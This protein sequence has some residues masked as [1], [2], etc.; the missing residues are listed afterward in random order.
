MDKHIR[1]AALQCNFQTE[2]ETLNMPA[3]WNEI[4]FN[5]EQLLQTHADLYSAVYDPKRHHDLLAKYA[6]NARKNNIRLIIYMNVHILGPS[7]KEHYDE[8]CT[9]DENG[10]PYK[11]YRTYPG[12]CLNSG[13]REYFYSCL[14]FLK[15]F[16]IEGIFFDGPTM[17]NCHCPHCQALFKKQTGKE[18]SEAT[19][20]EIT[21]FTT[22]N[23]MEFK[24]ELYRKV[25]EINPAWSSYYNEGL[26]SGRLDAEQMAYSL[27]SDDIIGTE[28]GFFFYDEP[29]KIPYWKCSSA[30]KLAEAVAGNKQTVVFFAG[31]HKAWGWFMHTDSE[32]KLCYTSAIANGASVW[33]GVH[34]RPDSLNRD[35]GK[36]IREM[37]QFDKKHD[38]LY[39]N[40][41]SAA[42]T[43]VFYSFNTAAYYAKSAES[44][45]L[46]NADARHN[47]KTPGN[48]TEAFQGALAALEHL[49]VPFDIVTELA[50][51]ALMKYKT[52]LVPGMA[53]LDDTS[54]AAMKQFVANG[55]LLIADGE[56]GFFDG[57]GKPRADLADVAELTGARPS[58]E[59]M[60]MQNFNYISVTDKTFYNDNAFGYI[61]APRWCYPLT[62]EAGAESAVLAPEPMAGCYASR[63][64]V[65]SIPVAASHKFGK[66]E[67]LYFAGGLFE[68]YG[69]YQIHVLR[70]W[71]AHLLA[72][73]PATYRLLGAKPGISITVR[74]C[75]E[76][77]LVHLTNFLGITRPLDGVIPLAGMKLTA[78]EAT[79]TDLRTG[80]SLSK[81][82]DGNFILPVQTEYAVFLLS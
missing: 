47:A 49:S 67:C 79:A 69:K 17:T 11:L 75:S 68:F 62:L 53:M 26:F 57:K 21:A 52:I 29:R 28:G 32:L 61:P 64:G 39:Q 82:A 6:E 72:K 22:R 71:F 16:D 59:W 77:T 13:W 37:V 38:A 18:M 55:G 76:G 30:A 3:R 25:K 56:F 66:G 31:D 65:P 12:S 44:S 7:L 74:K 41:T 35:S 63:P 4:G 15:E 24:H 1:I 42:E 46:Y 45:D 14:E 36:T 60:D 40:T 51:D 2:A 80:E 81:D 20:Q 78:P 48:Y 70:N 58:A 50:P 34:H 43:A 54:L 23:V 33:L 9:R 73:R 10:N 8:W 27:Q 5:F 19:T